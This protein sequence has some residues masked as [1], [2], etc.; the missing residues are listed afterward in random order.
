M[1]KTQ[2]VEF[3]VWIIRKSLECLIRINVLLIFFFI[4]QNLPS[5]K[6]L[7]VS[8]KTDRKTRYNDYI[9]ALDQIRLAYFEVRDEYSNSHYGKKYKDLPENEQNIVKDKIPITISIAEPEAIKKG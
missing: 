3:A 7:I 9:Q 6:K 1:I 2:Q 5:N 8:L 4:S